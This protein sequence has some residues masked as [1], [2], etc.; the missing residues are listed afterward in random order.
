MHNVELL[1]GN[2][3][4]FSHPGALLVTYQFS[5]SAN[6]Q[7]YGKAVKQTNPEI[8]ENVYEYSVDLTGTQ[9][10]P[11]AQEKGKIYWLMIVANLGQDTSKQW[12]WHEADGPRNNDYAVQGVWSSQIENWS[13]YIPCGGRE[14]AFALTVIPEPASLFALGAGLTCLAGFVIRKRRRSA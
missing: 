3:L 4:G 8:F 5:G 11:F 13:W 2:T 10:G 14:M 9:H 7:F 12:G 1:P 6:E